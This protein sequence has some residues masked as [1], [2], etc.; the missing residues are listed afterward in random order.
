MASSLSLSLGKRFIF[1]IELVFIL[2][3]P[4]SDERGMPPLSLAV[5]MNE[6]RLRLAPLLPKVRGALLFENP[7]ERELLF[8]VE[9]DSPMRRGARC[10]KNR[11]KVERQQHMISRFASTKLL[12]CELGCTV[13]Y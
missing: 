8:P 10:L 3:V 12:K 1:V 7:R 4:S 9:E 11:R 5:C 6:S 2:S 13:L